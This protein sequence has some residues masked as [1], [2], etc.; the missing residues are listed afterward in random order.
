[1]L[2]LRMVGWFGGGQDLI[3]KRFSSAL[4]VSFTDAREP[5]QVAE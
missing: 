5:S 4:H 3:M 2:P 1:L